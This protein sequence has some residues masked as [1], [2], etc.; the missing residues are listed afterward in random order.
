MRLDNRFDQAQA[1][2]ETPLRTAL[3]PAIKPGPNFVL[4]FKRNT[5]ARIAENRDGF[6]RFALNGDIH[7][8][9][10]GSIFDGIVE[11]VRKDLAHSRAVHRDFAWRWEIGLNGD[12]FFLR[13]ILIKLY[14]FAGELAEVHWFAMQLHHSRFGLGDIHERVQHIEHALGF[15]DTIGQGLAR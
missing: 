14:D 6:V 7:A 2:A 3:V 1:E 5:D 4:L 8:T 10:R 15:F 9:T 13:H 12:L 11:Q